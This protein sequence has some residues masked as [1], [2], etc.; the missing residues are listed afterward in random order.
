MSLPALQVLVCLQWLSLMNRP[1]CHLSG[2]DIGFQSECYIAIEEELEPGYQDVSSP[3]TTWDDWDSKIPTFCLLGC[4][5]GLA[6]SLLAL[7]PFIKGQQ[8]AA[9]AGDSERTSHTSYAYSVLFR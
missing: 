8:E 6:K 9:W 5:T 7:G 3:P 2:S 4:S 1:P